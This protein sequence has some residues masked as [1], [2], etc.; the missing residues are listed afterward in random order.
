MSPSNH[1]SGFRE[2]NAS[3]SARQI[4]VCAG[5]KTAVGAFRDI[6]RPIHAIAQASFQPV[7]MEI[8]GIEAHKM[9]MFHNEP[10]RE[11]LPFLIPWAPSKYGRIIFL[12]S[13]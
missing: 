3:D 13:S 4:S 10:P 11:L 7:D 2:I 1:S 12:R 9:M 6:Y 5:A 8:V